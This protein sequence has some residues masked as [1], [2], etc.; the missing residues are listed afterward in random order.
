MKDDARNDDA[1]LDDAALQEVAQRLGVR[2]AERLDVERAATAVVQRLRTEP[3]AEVW[4][5]IQPAWLRVAAAVVLLV[6]AG[7]VALEMRSKMLA[8]VSVTAAAGELRD[9]SAGQLRE[10]LEAV[11]QPDEE[12][13][14]SA[15]EVGLEQLSASQLRALLESLEG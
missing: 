15:Q 8:P 7:V 13:T 4:V 10:V 2:A 12:Q 14:V 1:R 9:L 5:W 11:G 3:R 6:G